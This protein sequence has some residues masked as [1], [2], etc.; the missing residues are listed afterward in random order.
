MPRDL[1]TICLKCLHKEPA[2]RYARSLDLAEDLHRWLA[3][4]PVL[5]RPVRL[6]ERAWK[7]CRRRPAVAGLLLLVALLTLGSMAAI[8]TLYRDAVEQAKI[9]GKERDAAR[10]AEERADKAR[11][12]AE[13]RSRM[14]Q[15][16]FRLAQC[17]REASAGNIAQALKLFDE[18][19]PRQRGWEHGHVWLQIAQ[20]A[21]QLAEQRNPRTAPLS[22]CFSRDGRL[23]AAGSQSKMISIWEAST[24]RLLHSMHGREEQ[25]WSVDLS[26]DG[27]WLASAA[28][29]EKVAPKG[30]NELLLWN[31]KTGERHRELKGHQGAVLGVRFAPDGSW[32][33]SHGADGKIHFWEFPSGKRLRTFDA[34]GKVESLAV[35]PE[36]K[37]LAYGS[38]KQVFLRHAQTGKV[39]HTL[40]G[41]SGTINSAAFSGDGKLP[42]Q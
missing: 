10:A 28:G 42:G 34:P 12:A 2:R 26:P 35:H 37:L 20:Q 8:V 22:I 41:F 23:L 1:E 32:L 31:T 15:Y 14:S 33:A 11:E 39:I 19:S 13:E 7:W 40:T 6:V 30:T 24:G 5:A 18:C 16:A 38:K 9:A 25:V 3:G 21:R 17:Q 29:P 4:E 27:Q 36:G